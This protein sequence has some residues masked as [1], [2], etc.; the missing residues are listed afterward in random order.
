[1]QRKPYATIGLGLR[2]THS[3]TGEHTLGGKI[4]GLGTQRGGG[5]RYL[6]CIVTLKVEVAGQLM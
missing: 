2:F 5:I 6:V 3:G 4:G 1:M